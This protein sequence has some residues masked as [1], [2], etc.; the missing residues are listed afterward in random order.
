MTTSTSPA[1]RGRTSTNRLYQRP[2]HSSRPHH[3]RTSTSRPRR[4]LHRPTLLKEQLQLLVSW[5]QQARHMTL[6]VVYAPFTYLFASVHFCHFNCFYHKKSHFSFYFHRKKGIPDQAKTSTDMIESCSS[7]ANIDKVSA[8]SANVDQSSG[9]VELVSSSANVAKRS[10]SSN[11]QTANVTR[12]ASHASHSIFFLFSLA[13]L[14]SYIL[15]ISHFIFIEKNA[16]R[17]RLGLRTT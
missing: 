11:V 6:T 9:M 2:T 4:R 15:A 8:S 17:I 14:N 5:K 13:W 3:R 7:L 16:F 10:P 1:H 12:S